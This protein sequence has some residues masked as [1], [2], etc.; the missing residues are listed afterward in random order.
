MV[1]GTARITIK[2]IPVPKI[3]LPAN[4]TTLKLI[5]KLTITGIADPTTTV[6]ITFDSSIIA[7][8]VKVGNNGKWTYEYQNFMLP[9]NHKIV[10]IAVKDRIESKPSNVTTVKIDP[11]AVSVFGKFVPVYLVIVPLLITIVFLLL[12]IIWIL[13]YSRNRYHQMRETAIAANRH[14]GAAVGF[15]LHKMRDRIRKYV[16]SI[17]QPNAKTKHE[18]LL[19][20]KDIEAEMLSTEKTIGKEIEKHNEEL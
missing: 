2:A 12:L 15:R 19:A 13:I 20:E 16:K 1:E 5:Q 9:G 14:T 8:G 7:R 11:T 17:G 10:A 18:T 3:I 6:N 4:N